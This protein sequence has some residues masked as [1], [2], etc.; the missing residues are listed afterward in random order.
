MDKIRRSFLWKGNKE[1]RNSHLVKWKNLIGIRSQ[2][3]PGIK[4]L[5]NQSKAL[6]VKWLWRYSQEL[7]TLWSSIIKIKYGELD[8]WVSKE[9]TTPYGVSLWR[10]IRSYWLSLKSHPTVKVHSG[11]KTLFWTD[12]M[13]G[14]ANIQDLFLDLFSLAQHQDKTVTEMWTYQGWYLVLRRL[15]SVWEIPRLTEFYKYLESFQGPQSGV[16]CLWWNGHS[17][18]IYK[19]REGTRFLSSW[20]TDQYLAMEAHLGS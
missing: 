4:N 20:D 8:S 10:I 13:M 15:L 12:K 3:G 1:K 9:V 14:S 11:N 7:Q 18:G 5:K 19:V 6:K 16:D 2:G 17:K